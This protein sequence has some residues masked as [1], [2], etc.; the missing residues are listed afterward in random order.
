MLKRFLLGC[1]LCFFCLAASANVT[2]ALL[3]L[4]SR[5]A[6]T[7]SPYMVAKMAGFELLMPEPVSL[8]YYKKPGNCEQNI[9]W[10]QQTEADFYIISVSQLCYGG[11]VASRTGVVSTKEAQKRLES[12][13]ELRKKTNGK[14]I[15]VFDTIQRLAITSSDSKA[16]SY[17]SSVHNWAILKDEV[18]NL[19]QED[20]RAELE[21]LEES[22]PDDILTDYLKAR[23]R[24]HIIN[25]ALIDMVN[26]GVI[27]YLIFAQDDASVT[28]LHRAERE[29]LKEKVLELG[30]TAKVNIFPGADEVGVVLVNRAITKHLGLEPSFEIFYRGVD[31]NIWIAAFE[32]ISFAENIRRHIAA[33]GAILSSEGSINLFVA[34][35]GGDNHA[36][37]KSMQ[38]KLEAGKKVVIC[39]VAITNRADPALFLAMLNNLEL[40]SLSGYAGWN[41]AG[42]TLGFALGQG[43]A[44]IAR[45]GL[46]GAKR[47]EAEKA[48]YEY[49]L[50]RIAKD[51]YYKNL[52]QGAIEG[53]ASGRGFNTINLPE[54]SLPLVKE[55]L[56]KQLLPYLFEFYVHYFANEKVGEYIVPPAITWDIDL[57]WPRFFEISIKPVV[58]LIGEDSLQP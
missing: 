53:W 5:P 55:E 15:Y 47:L 51:Y 54:Y 20:K 57:A 40:K 28:G 22:I 31:G 45:E 26:E 56:K 27:D 48:H 30:L 19:G 24:N 38:A 2:I 21:R 1:S 32:D 12:L 8:D 7:Y 23:A 52:V 36:F 34:T 49:L 35:P 25:Q 9:S 14:P 29:S 37:T 6:N 33:S 11:L 42:N 16:A 43:I 17:Y 39:D 50:H 3:P 41:T 58:D 18:E 44:A 10:L 46:T 4:D 13:R